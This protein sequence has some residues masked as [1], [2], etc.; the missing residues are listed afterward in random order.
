MTEN[1]VPIRDAAEEA[2]TSGT[3][4][5]EALRRV[6]VYDAARLLCDG[7][8]FEPESEEKPTWSVAV[9]FKVI[10]PMADGGLEEM[11]AHQKEIEDLVGE[12]PGASGFCFPTAE[13]DVSFYFDSLQEAEVV[14]NKF[15]S[16]AFSFPVDV[17]EIIDISEL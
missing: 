17:D 12:R 14:R 2:L 5:L 9:R 3:P 4:N 6:I 7:S 13:R 10:R 15:L 1:L 8:Y 11:D 16:H